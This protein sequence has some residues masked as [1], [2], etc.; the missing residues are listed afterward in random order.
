VKFTPLGG[1]V[2]VTVR[3]ENDE[4]ELQVIDSGMGIP[5]SFLPFVFDKFRQADS[6]FTR[7]HGGLG[8]GLAIS[9]HLVELHGG[10]IEARSAGDGTGATFVV[11]LPLASHGAREPELEPATASAARGVAHEIPKHDH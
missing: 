8:L 6:S 9:R 10:S 3:S 1:R 2:S 5:A 4:A 11:R 7:K